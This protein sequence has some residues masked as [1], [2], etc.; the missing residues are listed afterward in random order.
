MHNSSNSPSECPCS[1]SVQLEWRVLLHLLVFES[2]NMYFEDPKD[3]FSGYEEN[4][5][6]CTRNCSRVLQQLTKAE[7]NVDSIIASSVEI[8]GELSEAEGYLRAMDVEVRSIKGPDKKKIEAKLADYKT[9]FREATQKFTKTKFEAESAA[10][11]K[12]ATGSRGKLLNAN[13]K[14]D[15]STDTLNQSRALVNETEQ[16]GAATLTD[17]ENQ[18]EVLLDAHG[19]VAA[20]KVGALSKAQLTEFLNENL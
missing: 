7:G 6:N 11:K 3:R 16:I 20:T 2:I 13:A 12:G 18:R 14:L 4:F 15:Q 8:E 1:L 5:L 9:E 10:L 19:N 17:M